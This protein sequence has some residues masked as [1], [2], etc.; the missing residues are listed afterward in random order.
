MATLTIP[1]RPTTYN[2]IKMRSRLEAKFAADLDRTP[3]IEWWYEPRAYANGRG[4]YLP[5]FEVHD[6]GGRVSQPMFFE[7]R[8]TLARAYLA[9]TQMPIIWDS[10]P[11]AQLWIAVPGS[12]W[13]WAESG[14]RTWRV[15]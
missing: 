9:M 15:A 1:A 10:E 11:S 4:Q 7:V 2:G 8:P 3:Q 14:D 6:L 5:D 12:L 13:F